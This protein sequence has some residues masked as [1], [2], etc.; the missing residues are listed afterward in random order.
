[1]SFL[2]GRW[3]SERVTREGAA[4]D[5]GFAVAM[6]NDEHYESRPTVKARKW[7]SDSTGGTAELCLLYM[8][9]CRCR[10]PDDGDVLLWRRLAA[11]CR[12]G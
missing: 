4:E 3:P 12:W 8:K 2:L 10:K 6:M 1:M 5:E 7:M 11:S 9:G